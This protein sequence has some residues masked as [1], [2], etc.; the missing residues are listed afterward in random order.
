MA[1]SVLCSGHLVR[2]PLG[3]HSWH[4][5]QYLV[6]LS[7]LGHRVTFFEHYGWPNSCYDPQQNT[8]T[9]DPRYGIQYMKSIFKRVDLDIDWCYIDEQGSYHGMSKSDLMDRCRES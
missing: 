1:L 2:Y 8:M 4:H 6:G 5:L 3:G 7:R 9:M